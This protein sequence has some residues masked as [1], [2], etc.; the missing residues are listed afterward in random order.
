MKKLALTSLLAVFAVSGAH[1]ANIIDGNPLYRPGEGHFY[2]E[3]NIASH[4]ENADTWGITEE[5]GFGV[6]DRL[7]IGLKT[8][9][10]EYEWFDKG[11]D[12]GVFGV[13]LNYRLID[14]GNWKGDV[15]G[16]YGLNPVWGYQTSF[17]DKDATSYNWAIGVRGG[18]VG[19]GWTVAAHF[20]FDYSNSESFNWNDDGIHKLTFGVDGQFVL[21]DQWNLV[22]GVEYTGLTDSWAE[23]DGHWSGKFGVNYN[24]DAS[25]YIGLYVSGDID[26]S[27]GD[28]EFEDGVGFGAKFGIDF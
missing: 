6:T 21:T 16:S 3:F 10:N 24:L 23:D 17:L 25:K 5:F 2:N 19:D 22:A 11:A 14:M 4:S 26:H 1:A 12:W 7:S 15:Y 8:S 18:Y 13:G 9:V 28:W 27:T 20:A